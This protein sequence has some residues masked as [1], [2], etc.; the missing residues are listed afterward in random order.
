L[1]TS[2]TVVRI[3]KSGQFRRATS[4]SV[5]KT[6]PESN[7]TLDER[8]D[9]VERVSLSG[10]LQVRFNAVQ[11]AAIAHRRAF[12]IM[13]SI[14]VL[15]ATPSTVAAPVTTQPASVVGTYN[16]SQMEIAAGLE[17]KPDGRFRYALF[18]GALACSS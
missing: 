5:S 10:V 13:A 17:L 15:L 16:G 4:S 11:A 12:G 3:P 9:Q 18:Y 7:R 6:L 1:C 8:S 2:D 14:A